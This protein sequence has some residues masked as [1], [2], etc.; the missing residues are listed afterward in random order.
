MGIGLGLIFI[1]ENWYRYRQ[2]LKLENQLK[3][4]SVKKNRSGPKEY[5]A[6]R[7]TLKVLIKKT[8]NFEIYFY[9]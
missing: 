2:G 4:V 8:L 9:L 5:M 1:V 3:S 7:A 6:Q